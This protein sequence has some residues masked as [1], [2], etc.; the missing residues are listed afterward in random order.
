MR[1]KEQK[2]FQ[3]ELRNY[4]NDFF[5]VR[6]Y[7]SEYRRRICFICNFLSFLAVFWLHFIMEQ[8]RGKVAV[9]TGAS[10]GIGSKIACKLVE[11]GLKVRSSLL[12]GAT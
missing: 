6:G 10:S 12:K 3:G 9:I 4:L 5:Q 7:K 11:E 2:R 8:W 1:E